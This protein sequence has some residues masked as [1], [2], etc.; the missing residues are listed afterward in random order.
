MATDVKATGQFVNP[1]TT[2]APELKKDDREVNF[3]KLRRKLESQ[4]R[5]YSDRLSRQEQEI[6]QL[7]GHLQPQQRNEDVIIEDGELVEGAKVKRLLVQQEEKL[8]RKASEIARQTFQQID[9]ENFAHKIKYAYPDF[10]DVVNA[11]NAQKLQEKDPEF[12]ALLGEVKDEFRR[13]ELA[14]KKIKQIL[15]DEVAK[16]VVKAQEVAQENL[17]T[18]SNYYTP[19][20]QGPMTNPYG[21]EFDVRNKSSREQAYA[22]I[23]NA[24]K[25]GF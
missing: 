14:Y 5:E 11:D 10:D 24:Q 21:F 8:L 19:A 16:P 4:E 7:R 25:K 23:K 20:G 22:R 1:E 12:T 6:Q 15:K 3:E 2:T 9:S 17:K 13:R 18:A